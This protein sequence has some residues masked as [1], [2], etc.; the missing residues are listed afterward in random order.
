MFTS[1]YRAYIN[2]LFWSRKIG[3]FS[4]TISQSYCHGLAVQDQVWTML[5]HWV[6]PVFAH[7]PLYLLGDVHMVSR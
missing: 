1:F 4:S 6:E 2:V 5:R 3:V 7:R